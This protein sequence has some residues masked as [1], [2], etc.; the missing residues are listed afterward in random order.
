M[1][2]RKDFV[3]LALGEPETK[4]GE[5]IIP[6][7]SAEISDRCIVLSV[8][9]D[10]EDLNVGDIV[11]RPDVS[12]VKHRTGQTCDFE[13]NG[14]DCIYVKDEDIA[15][16]F[17]GNTIELEQVTTEYDASRLMSESEEA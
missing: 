1:R 15:V 2:A 3:V 9:P 16:R 11:Q 12:I 7:K 8:G 6:S 13:H 10:V 5:I 14:N 4:K 17:A